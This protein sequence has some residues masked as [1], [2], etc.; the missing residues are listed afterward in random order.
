MRKRERPS[1]SMIRLSTA[2]HQPTDFLQQLIKIDGFMLRRNADRVR[3]G[4][5]D[6]NAT[7]QFHFDH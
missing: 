2:L 6:G 7:L 5:K 1:H 3:S 4:S